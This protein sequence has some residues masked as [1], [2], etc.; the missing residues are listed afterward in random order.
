M[1]IILNCVLTIAIYFSDYF[2][3]AER[4]AIIKNLGL[5]EFI[6]EHGVIIET[7]KYIVSICIYISFILISLTESI[8][9]FKIVLTI[10]IA[11]CPFKFY[12]MYKQRVIRKKF[13]AENG[14]CEQY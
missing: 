12:I 6:A 14:T 7:I 5:F 9:V 4:D 1:F 13:E 8:V 11:V 2:G 10:M 3:D